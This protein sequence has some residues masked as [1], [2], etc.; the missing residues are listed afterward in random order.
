MRLQCGH[1][2]HGPRGRC[3]RHAPLRTNRLR[4]VLREMQCGPDAVPIDSCPPFL[5]YQPHP[6]EDQCP[7]HRRD[8]RR[9]L[10]GSNCGRSPGQKVV[11]QLQ[12][13]DCRPAPRFCP[14]QVPLRRIQCLRAPF[15]RYRRAESRPVRVKISGDGSPNHSPIDRHSEVPSQPA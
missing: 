6:T 12:A 3:F 1:Y 7:Q 14:R 4:P 10:A 11:H 9:F 2:R 8:G 5:L 15:G 13:I